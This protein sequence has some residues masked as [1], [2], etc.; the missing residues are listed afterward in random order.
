MKSFWKKYGTWIWLVVLF[1]A[2]VLMIY[3]RFW[4]EKP[5]KLWLRWVQFS[6]FLVYFI[7][8]LIKIVKRYKSGIANRTLKSDS[9]LFFHWKNKREQNKFATDYD[10]STEVG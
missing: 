5:E 4:N 10:S 7:E 1:A 8:R 3:Y 2:M 6:F 9:L